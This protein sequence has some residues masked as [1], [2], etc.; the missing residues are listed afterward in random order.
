MRVQGVRIRLR[1]SGF[2]PRVSHDLF[3]AEE[4]VEAQSCYMGS[5]GKES[6]GGCWKVSCQDWPYA[7]IRKTSVRI[8]NLLTKS[9]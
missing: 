1:D 5:S 4:R 6:S 3:G 7:Y 2:G 8:L 9:P